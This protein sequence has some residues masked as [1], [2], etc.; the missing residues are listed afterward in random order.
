MIPK[1]KPID[2]AKL[3]E[4]RMRYYYEVEQPRSEMA[5]C[6]ICGTVLRRGGLAEEL[7]YHQKCAYN[8]YMREW[9]SRNKLKASTKKKGRRNTGNT[10]A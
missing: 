10:A 6:S 5:Y 1:S 3:N 8:E 7:G 9:R 4:A 2:R